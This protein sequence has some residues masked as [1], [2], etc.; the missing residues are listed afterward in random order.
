MK[1]LAIILGLVLVDVAV[2]GTYQNAGGVSASDG[3]GLIPLLKNDFEPGTKGNFLAWFAA[4]LIIGMV[5]YIPQLKPIS[6]L[7]LALV[8]VVLFLAPNNATGSG[9]F[10]AQLEQTVSQPAPAAQQQKAG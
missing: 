3:Q 9:G 7:M 10:F 6:N 5:G 4:I 1:V 2:R 8:I